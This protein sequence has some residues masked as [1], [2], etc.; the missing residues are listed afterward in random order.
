MKASEYNFDGIVGPTHNY[1]GL[2]YGNVASIT[3]KNLVS[4][5]KA[6]AL[7]GLEKMLFLSSLGIKQAVLP[8]HERPYFPIFRAL[9]YNEDLKG[10]MEKLVKHHPALL[11]ACYSAAAMW[12]ANAATISPSSDT[13]DNKIH[14][15]PANLIYQFHRSIESHTTA[16]VLK[17]IFHDSSYF[18]HHDPLPPHLLFGDEGA[19]NHM[20]LCSHHA[21]KGIEIFIYG[22]RGFSD[23][24]TL[25]RYPARQTLEASQSIARLHQLD[26]KK[27]VFIQQNP[28]AINAGVFHNDVISVANENTLFFHEMAYIH[29]HGVISSL[30]ELFFSNNNSTMNLVEVKDSEVSLAEAVKTYLFNSQLITLPDQTMALIAPIE[31][32]NT[33]KVHQYLL[34]LVNSEKCPIKQVYYQDLKESMQNGGGPAC[35]RLKVVMNAQEEASILPSVILNN[36]LYE[37]LKHLIKSRY[38]D[39]LSPSDLHD[40]ELI[41]ES[42]ETLDQISRILHLGPIYAFQES[43]YFF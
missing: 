42:R 22:K 38:R 37:K 9:G 21:K 5:P 23:P 3:N 33:Q 12:T 14:I 11:T 16:Q 15:T 28:D 20:R 24:N 1:S 27:T 7:Q 26:E 19:A 8:P 36:D 6:A 18:V 41:E 4:N 39:R 2:S 35:L 17:K 31:C 10:V 29:T 34:S 25:Q 13:F 30:Q 43:K 32:K 40:P